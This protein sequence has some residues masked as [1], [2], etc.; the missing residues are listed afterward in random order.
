MITP[1]VLTSC[2]IGN[3]WCCTCGII[4]HCQSTRSIIDWLYEP[5]NSRG[6]GWE[7][8]ITSLL[9]QCEVFSVLHCLTPFLAFSA[10]LG[11]LKMAVQAASRMAG[12][13][14]PC[15][16]NLFFLLDKDVRFY[17]FS[18]LSL[19][20]LFKMHRNFCF[21]DYMITSLRRPLFLV[22]RGRDDKNVRLQPGPA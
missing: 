10:G 16:K 11:V 15:A 9:V 5:K 6:G 13:N 1:I 21:L 18:L 8:K 4:G 12:N 20:T 14:D 22:V 2:L 17:T 3:C 7:V 19:M